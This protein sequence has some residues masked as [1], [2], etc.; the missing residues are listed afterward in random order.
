MGELTFARLLTVGAFPE[1]QNVTRA[2]QGHDAVAVAGS[3]SGQHEGRETG[4]GGEALYLYRRAD[5]ALVGERV[6]P[7]T[8]NAVAF[9]P[10]APVAVVG[11]G[12]Y[13]GGTFFTGGAL[14][15]NW[16]TGQARPLLRDDREVV[17]VSFSAD[18]SQ[19]HLTCSPPDDEA[20]P[21]LH[22]TYLLPLPSPS[23]VELA[24]LTVLATFPPPPLPQAAYQARQR[25]EL[26]EL[27]ALAAA[28]G[29][30]F[31]PAPMVWDLLFLPDGWLVSAH[32]RATVRLWQ[33]EE[34]SC[35]QW[36]L[37]AGNR[38]VQLF[39]TGPRELVVVVE[40]NRWHA[41]DNALT[42]FFR[43]DL[44]DGVPRLLARQA[45]LLSQA[46]DGTFLA[47]QVLD[48]HARHRPADLLLTDQLQV[49]K[50]LRLGSYDMLNHYLRLDGAPHHYCLLGASP[51]TR[52]KSLW[53][54]QP[55]T[56]EREHFAPLDGP[57]EQWLNVV[58]VYHP[59]RLVVA[60]AILHQQT[61]SYCLQAFTP[62]GQVAWRHRL[63]TRIV[64]ATRGPGGRLVTA[65]RDGQ[66]AVWRLAD[67]QQRSTQAV[68]PTPTTAQ[69]LSLASND[70][71]LAVGLSD[72]RIAVYRW[73]AA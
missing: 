48:G 57:A 35:Q 11:Y 31:T 1:A 62:T 43:L 25:A 38:C 39:A 7:D 67:G 70:T 33:V 63:P 51:P 73:A 10:H 19:L 21:F 2:W 13:D 17:D 52:H 9:H 6:L 72:G 68:L 64:A 4:T 61:T 36:Q 65:T 30:D 54:L 15:W 53:R 29:A 40:T 50:K 3:W 12:G 56:G 20:H 49:A 71:H 69:P 23:P 34:G 8:V 60:G 44:A 16:Q 18:G 46:A 41:P 28:H 24:Q 42:T 22:T 5:L 58:A 27:A 26:A 14:W 37:E 55:T 59:D 45:H 32:E 66:L 47:R